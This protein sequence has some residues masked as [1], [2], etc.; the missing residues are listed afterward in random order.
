MLEFEKTK[1]DKEKEIK[2]LK[3]E[4]DVYVDAIEE[5]NKEIKDIKEEMEK[6]NAE[7]SERHQDRKKLTDEIVNLETQTLQQTCRIEELESE[8]SAIK[9]LVPGESLGTLQDSLADGSTLKKAA[10]HNTGS[11]DFTSLFKEL[12]E[13]RKSKADL[14]DQVE[15]ISS[16]RNDF[17]ER[18]EKRE[19]VY[20]ALKEEYNKTL[21]EKDTLEEDN[22]VSNDSQPKA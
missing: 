21:G 16:E 20:K 14:L 9:K 18:L 7:I 1:R 12:E 11:N 5:K 8:I 3:D 2:S 15:K 6:L 22:K 13:L 10:T 19:M 17:K 4:I